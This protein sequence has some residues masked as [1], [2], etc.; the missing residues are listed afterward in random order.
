MLTLTFCAQLFQL[1]RTITFDSAPPQHVGTRLFFLTGPGSGLCYTIFRIFNYWTS[2]LKCLV[3]LALI[4]TLR[5][6]PHRR[7]LL[8]C[9]AVSDGSAQRHSSLLRL[10]Q[11]SKLLLCS[12]MLAQMLISNE[13]LHRPTKPDK[14]NCALTGLIAATLNSRNRSSNFAA[15][16]LQ[17]NGN[18]LDCIVLRPMVSASSF[19]NP[20][21]LVPFP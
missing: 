1:L 8:P 14:T 19:V 4:I 9:K 5:A 16:L 7:L 10:L 2:T 3:T 18:I 15:T 21:S 13:L 12:R 11:L 20:R 6:A 17:A